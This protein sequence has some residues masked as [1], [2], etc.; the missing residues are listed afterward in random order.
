MSKKMD[1]LTFKTTKYLVLNIL[2]Y[3]F[4]FSSNPSYAL[5]D[6]N[7]KPLELQADSA[8]INNDKHIGTYQGDV[9]FDQGST[10]IRAK[11]AITK[12]NAKNQL[13]EAII[14]GDDKIQAHYWTKISPEKA[15][16]HA[17]ANTIYYFPDKHLITLKGHARIKQGENSYSA[18]IIS[19]NTVSQHVYSSNQGMPIKERTI[20]I[21]HSKAKNNEQVI[22]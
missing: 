8:D 4:L 6:D 22:R 3:A 2:I 16:L 18:P 7:K 15:E 17:Y 21:F 1:K 13:T 5:K 11:K 10:H 19:Y 14:S 12:S 20:I 9:A